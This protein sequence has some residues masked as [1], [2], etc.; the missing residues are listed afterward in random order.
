MIDQQVAGQGGDPGVEAALGRVEA[1]QVGV[2][3]D[4]DV[5]G[6]VF[7]VMG[8]G[9]ETV[10]EAVYPA[11]LG[12]HQLRPGPGIPIEAAPHQS[13]PVQLWRFGPSF[14]R[15]LAGAHHLL[16]QAACSKMGSTRAFLG[17]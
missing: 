5:L 8:G 6:Q 16:V 13:G 1:A 11:L 17:Q 15:R 4:E 2:E 14:G 7:G 3:L 10:A 9:G 12:H